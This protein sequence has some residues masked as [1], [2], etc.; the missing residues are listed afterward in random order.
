MVSARS[1]VH[2]FEEQ[3]PHAHIRGKATRVMT[4]QLISPACTRHQ[5]SLLSVHGVGQAEPVWAT[6]SARTEA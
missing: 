3:E 1:T 6:V 5:G 2:T 4:T